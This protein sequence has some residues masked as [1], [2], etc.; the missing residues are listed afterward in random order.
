MS[1]TAFSK[2][3][4]KS[5]A[6]VKLDKKVFGVP[7]N[8][9]LLKNAYVSYLANGRPNLAKTQRRGEVR[10]GGQKPWRQK[11]TG[12]ARFGSS[13]NPLWRGGGVAFGPRGNENY[14]QRLNLSAKRQALRQALSLAADSGKLVVIE[15]LVFSS[16]KTKDAAFLLAKIGALGNV[17]IAVESKSS[18]IERPLRNLSNV[19]LVQAKYLNVFDVLNADS[20]ILT[21]S[22]LPNI[23]AWLGSRK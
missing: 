14:S 12:R 2:S 3:G 22:A 13:R 6:P 10:G 5:Q 23:S 19:K 11:G 20:L 21:A 1:V 18:E 8:D 7:P 15:D 9:E 4:N 16:A 17:L